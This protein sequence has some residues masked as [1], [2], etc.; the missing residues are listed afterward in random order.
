MFDPHPETKH[1][2]VVG[3]LTEQQVRQC[4][5]RLREEAPHLRFSRTRYDG[6]FP[7]VVRFSLLVHPADRERAWPIIRDVLEETSPAITGR[8][9]AGAEKDIAA[10][11][12]QHARA[13]DAGDSYAG[14]RMLGGVTSQLQYLI[15][16]ILRPAKDDEAVEISF[17]GIAFQEV[18]TAESG[19]FQALGYIYAGKGSAC[20]YQQ[21]PLAAE[22]WAPMKGET[23]DRFVV[24]LGSLERF[25]A[26]GVL[27]GSVPD[28]H[29]DKHTFIRTTIGQGAAVVNPHPVDWAFTFVKHWNG[30]PSPAGL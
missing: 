17:D 19:R 1:T 29:L 24:Q 22:L 5:F 16:Y 23:L 30:P 26:E 8:R 14:R 7:T 18:L 2:A 20:F 3:D 9:G 10:L 25:V 11:I 6:G 13:K 27:K 28:Y 12:R 15:E 21:E 4:E